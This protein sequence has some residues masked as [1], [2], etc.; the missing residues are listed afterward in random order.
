MGRALRFLISL[1]PV[2]AWAHPLDGRI[3]DTR[4]HAFV[5]ADAVY[6]RAAASRY[7]LLGEIHDSVPQHRLQAEFLKALGSRPGP[8]ALALEQ[9]DGE[10]QPALDQARRDGV[11]DPDRLAAVGGFDKD[12]WDWDLYRG[13]FVAAAAQDWP[14]LAANLSRKETREIARGTVAPALPELPAAQQGAIERDIVDGHCGQSPPKDLLARMAL[15]QRARDARMAQ[16][17]AGFPGRAVLVAGAGHA[18]R[19]RAVPFYLPADAA[20]LV[21]AFVETRDEA[22]RPGDYDGE[23]YDLLWF[24]P[25]TPR[26]DPCADFPPLKGGG[27]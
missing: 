11:R 12:G 22:T 26:K 16:V 1:L 2:L 24:T 19:D 8:W 25:A 21:V 17:L 18:R 10:Y 27:G 9:L 20:S 23:S 3:W 5:S 13:L 4:A 6:E 15:A 14:L 7:V